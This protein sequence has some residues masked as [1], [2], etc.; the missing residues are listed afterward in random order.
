MISIV[1]AMDIVERLRVPIWTLD[2]DTER[3]DAA[4][5]IERLRAA[6]QYVLQRCEGAD[7][8]WPI[9]DMAAMAR[10]ALGLTDKQRHDDGE[11]PHD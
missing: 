6:L 10:A 11:R 9:E 7:E 3:K 5:E 8:G 4:N 1:S 2:Y